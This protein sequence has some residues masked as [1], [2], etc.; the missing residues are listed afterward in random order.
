M[1]YSP[2]I[3][4]L[5]VRMNPKLRARLQSSL[6]LSCKDEI[7]TSDE[8]VHFINNGTVPVCLEVHEDKGKSV[9]NGGVGP[10]M[11]FKH[12][13]DGDA[14]LLDPVTSSVT[15]V[16]PHIPLSISS[17]SSCYDN[18]DEGAL[19]NS[20]RH[21]CKRNRKSVVLELKLSQKEV[22]MK[23]APEGAVYQVDCCCCLCCC[24]LC[25]S[26]HTSCDLVIQ[27]YICTP[28]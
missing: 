24:C 20:T 27:L 28:G 8:V 21:A 16:S 9:K 22:E 2:P 3:T 26:T 23:G 19:P 6:S 15:M 17:S 1:P 13:P 12:I 5:K 18:S 4:R 14:T 11:F 7:S 25:S 10:E